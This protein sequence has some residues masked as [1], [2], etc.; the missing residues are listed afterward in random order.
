MAGLAPLNEFSA[1]LIE[2]RLLGV[3]K[4]PKIM[5]V[6][7]LTIAASPRQPIAFSNRSI[8]AR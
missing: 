7:H 1:H 4:T 3:D 2:D 5:R 6:V 8:L